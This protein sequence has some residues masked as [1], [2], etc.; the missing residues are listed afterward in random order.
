MDWML[1]MPVKDLIKD[2]L[3]EEQIEYEMNANVLETDPSKDKNNKLWF[4]FRDFT[5]F[6]T[7]NVIQ[8]TA[9]RKLS[10]WRMVTK[11]EFKKSRLSD[12]GIS[13]WRWDEI[14]GKPIEDLYEYDSEIV[15][16]IQKLNSNENPLKFTKGLAKGYSV[17]DSYFVYEY[18]TEQPTESKTSLSSQ[19][20]SQ[21]NWRF[22]TLDEIQKEG[23]GF[24][25]L[26]EN[27]I[28]KY[29]GKKFEDIIVSKEYK[30]RMLEINSMKD[31]IKRKKGITIDGYLFPHTFFTTDPL[32]V[33]AV[34]GFKLSIETIPS[35]LKRDYPFSA[36]IGDR[37]SP[38]QS[39]GK[40]Y[41]RFENLPAAKAELFNTF[42]KGNDGAWWNLKQVGTEWRWE[43][44]S[45]QPSQTS[46]SGKN[47]D[48]MIKEAAEKYAQDRSISNLPPYLKQL[49]I[50]NQIKQKGVV[51]E[52]NSINFG[53]IDDS[54]SWGDGCIFEVMKTAHPRVTVT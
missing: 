1:G 52:K 32:P 19:Q 42:F 23:L 25:G 18:P 11:E 36:N 9:Q 33:E 7:S 6:D 49:A 41:S 53:R 51:N 48:Q 47:I 13:E 37:K 46:T 3:T 34:S 43:K 31:S 45:P 54:A 4:V 16:V 35:T 21:E 2:D 30:T 10:G 5:I 15:E 39:A 27:L 50:N 14:Y 8:Q 12:I 28:S 44:A 24:Y 20:T 38:S 26:S 17:I 22:K 40:L 29:T